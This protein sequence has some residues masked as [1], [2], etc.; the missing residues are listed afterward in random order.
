MVSE[1]KQHCIGAAIA[2]TITGVYRPVNDFVQCN[3]TS[4]GV[5][6]PAWFKD[7]DKKQYVVY[8]T[9][10]PNV[11]LEI[12]EVANSG[13]KEG[14]EWVGNAHKLLKKDDQGFKDGF[15][16][17]A[18]YIFKRGGVYFLA[19]STHY[20]ADGS[21]DIQ[22]ATSE[23][24]KGPYTRAKE[25]LLKT[26]DKFGCN[27][28]GPGSASFQRDPKGNDKVVNMIFHGLQQPLRPMRRELYTATVQV[29]G[30]RLY[31]K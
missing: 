30:T 2:D 29:N 19:Y 22:Y 23:K 4:N 5:I 21:Y 28:T 10:R 20:Y 11:Y 12:R 17:E 31:I 15:N 8:K 16:L 26:T 14:V 18:P 3:R 1:N 13:P 6:D 25:P 24:V 9:D 27:I 7:D